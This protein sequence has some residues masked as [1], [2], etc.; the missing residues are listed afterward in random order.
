M[1][2][3]TF[4]RSIDAMTKAEHMSIH[5]VREIYADDHAIYLISDDLSDSC[6]SLIEQK[7]LQEQE[8]KSIVEQLLLVLIYFES[9]GYTMKNLHPNNI[10]LKQGE[11]QQ[12]LITDVGLADMPGIQPS[13]EVHT[14]FL[15]PELDYVGGGTG[16]DTALDLNAITDKNPGAADIWSIGKIALF[17][18]RG[19]TDKDFDNFT[20]LELDS[21]WID[22]LQ[23]SLQKNPDERQ[24]AKSLL[25]CKLFMGKSRSPTQKNSKT[26]ALQANMTSE[27]IKSYF[28][29][30]VF[31]QVMIGFFTSNLL[32]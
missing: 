10:F 24:T 25:R 6:K 11:S 22:F 9:I 12:L 16:E 4:A 17:L 26:A 31:E 27:R 5:K 3:A 18:L 19:I 2:G 7:D 21:G 13:M 28:E 8:V 32:F 15:A 30:S 1:K 29:T 20:E 14:Q 23:K